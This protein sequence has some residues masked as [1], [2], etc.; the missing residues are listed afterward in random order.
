MPPVPVHVICQT[1]VCV[2]V[3]GPDVTLEYWYAHAPSVG[4]PLPSDATHG[5]PGPLHATDEPPLPGVK[6]SSAGVAVTVADASLSV[7][8][9]VNRFQVSGVVQ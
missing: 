1:I 6:S 7:A 2:D 9:A 8:V 5:R 4:A 3:I